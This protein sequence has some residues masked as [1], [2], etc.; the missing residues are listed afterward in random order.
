MFRTDRGKIAPDLAPAEDPVLVFDVSSSAG[1]SCIMPKEVRTGST[2][3]ARNNSVR[4]PTMR[5]GVVAE[6]LLAD[7]KSP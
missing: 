4:T 5:S 7:T 3:G 1:R 6:E 2:R